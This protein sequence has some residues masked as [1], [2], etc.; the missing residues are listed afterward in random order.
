[1][2][3]NRVGTEAGVR[4]WGGSRVIDPSGEI[5][6]QAPFWEPALI[7]VDVDVDAAHRRRRELPLLA[8][9]RLALVGREVVRLIDEGG[10]T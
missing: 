1:V 9:A 3:V 7:T 6:A 10:D 2:F 5:L 8:E 4:F